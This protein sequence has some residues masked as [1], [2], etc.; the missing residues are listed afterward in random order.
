MYNTKT[1]HEVRTVS[2]AMVVVL[3]AGQGPESETQAALQPASGPW[4][5]RSDSTSRFGNP[6]PW[7]ALLCRHLPCCAHACSQ[8]GASHQLVSWRDRR[9]TTTQGQHAFTR[10]TS[11]HARDCDRTR[12]SSRVAEGHRGAAVSAVSRLRCAASW[13]GRRL[14]HPQ[15]AP[16][17]SCRG[18]QRENASVTT[19][20]TL[21]HVHLLKC[22]VPIAREAAILG[23]ERQRWWLTSWTI[24]CKS[25]LLQVAQQCGLYSVQH[26]N[27]TR[28]KVVVP[29]TSHSHIVA[30]PLELIKVC[31]L[32][33]FVSDASNVA[34][35]CAG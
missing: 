13:L 2:K 22:H 3:L 25:N 26:G 33:Q 20:R 29:S 4:S 7:L 32:S 8:D 27:T 14:H 1:L 11:R 24:C 6:K 31:L 15:A 21:A 16:H 17:C 9:T 23:V 18:G 35:Q 30:L 28:C 34:L 5:L 12:V 10:H 19:R